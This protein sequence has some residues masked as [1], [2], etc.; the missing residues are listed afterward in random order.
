MLSCV[1]PKQR[2]PGNWLPL[3]SVSC[4]TKCSR[5]VDTYCIML[6]KGKVRLKYLQHIIWPHQSVMGLPNNPFAPPP[7]PPTH[8]HTDAVDFNLLPDTPPQRLTLQPFTN[9]S[10]A[11]DAT[12]GWRNNQSAFV[13]Q[14][15]TQQ[16]NI[17]LKNSSPQCTDT[18]ECT[19]SGTNVGMVTPLLSQP[20]VYPFGVSAEC[21]TNYKDGNVS[22]LAAV[23]PVPVYSKWVECVVSCVADT[24]IPLSPPP[25]PPP[26]PHTHTHNS[27]STVPIPG[28]CS[29]TSS[30]EIDPQLPTTFS[31]YT[32]TV[33]FQVHAPSLDPLPHSLSPSSLPPPPSSLSPS[34]PPSLPPSFPPFLPSS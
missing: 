9:Y 15:H 6:W 33:Y 12:S 25:P 30:L 11:V 13:F 3:N 24:L 22:V 29:L 31:N 10:F 19:T 28:G 1:Q 27:L 5:S 17:T 7:P 14:L 8:T 20:G 34:L 32:T 18:L 16:C 23:V 4:G 26:P 2:R 21:G